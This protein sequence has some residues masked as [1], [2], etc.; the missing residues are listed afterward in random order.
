[1]IR[2]AASHSDAVHYGQRAKIRD[3]DDCRLQCITVAAAV[4][5]LM[6]IP[7]ISTDAFAIQL[8]EIVC[9]DPCFE[10]ESRYIRNDV[11]FGAPRFRR[12]NKHFRKTLTVGE[13][14]RMGNPLLV[15]YDDHS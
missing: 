10:V 5:V 6:N 12:N 1:M 13:R 14:L 8:V 3:R 7:A 9:E 11:A 4:S 2:R 15:S